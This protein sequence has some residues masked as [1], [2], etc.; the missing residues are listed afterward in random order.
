MAERPKMISGD[1]AAVTRHLFVL[2]RLI[3]VSK[4]ILASY[5]LLTTKSYR[6]CIAAPGS[7]QCFEKPVSILPRYLLP[8]CT[9]AKEGTK[10][11]TRRAFALKLHQLHGQTSLV[12]LGSPNSHRPP[13]LGTAPSVEGFWGDLPN[14]V[15]YKN[16]RLPIAFDR[17]CSR[18]FRVECLGQ[19][20]TDEFANRSA[21][22]T[23]TTSVEAQE[24]VVFLLGMRIKHNYR[25]QTHIR[26][27]IGTQ[28]ISAF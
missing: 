2:G 9:V 17:S 24:W 4:D 28:V 19:F 1:R 15:A 16:A 3:R 12:D 14:W 5:D 10:C 13:K 7:I 11:F 8:T 23:P 22:E 27:V 21:M 26:L 18:G 20:R 25:E 6:A